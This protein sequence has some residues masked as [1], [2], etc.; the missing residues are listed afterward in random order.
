MVID[1]SSPWPDAGRAG[2]TIT[3]S[4][5]RPIASATSARSPSE[6]ARSER[7]SRPRARR[8]ALVRA[9][10]NLL[11]IPARAHGVEVRLEQ[12]R[13]SDAVDLALAVPGRDVRGAQRAVRGRR[14]HA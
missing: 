14:G 4:T 5:R 3:R 1:T 12:E 8:G 2:Y 13:G 6:T 10:A 7:G 9:R 11:P